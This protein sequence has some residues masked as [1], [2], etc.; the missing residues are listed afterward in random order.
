[1]MWATSACPQN[2]RLP[3]MGG[4]REAMAKDTHGV[5]VRKSR[6]SGL[7]K[8]SKKNR[9]DVELWQESAYD[10]NGI[11]LRTGLNIPRLRYPC[12]G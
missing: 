7:P 3:A 12:C 2:G 8:K 9:S 11:D 4:G 5:D 6:G 10:R 1:M